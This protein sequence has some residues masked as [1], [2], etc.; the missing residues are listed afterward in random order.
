MSGVYAVA[1]QKGGV[2]K[3]TT[4]INL[5]AALASKSR[6]SLLIDLDPQG[7]ASSGSGLD[8]RALARTTADVLSGRAD[9]NDCILQTE[10]RYDLL[11]ANGELAALETGLLERFEREYILRKAVQTIAGRYRHIFIDCP[12]AQGP[13][14]LN[15][16]TAAQGVIV[17]IQC[18]YYAL[19]GLSALR[20]TVDRVRRT[21]NPGLRIEGILRT[22]YD[23]R[24]NLARDVSAE[25]LRHFPEV[26]Y[27]TIVPRNV[28]LAEAPSHGQSA[29]LYDPS[30]SGAGAYRTLAA[31]I[32][33]REAKAEQPASGD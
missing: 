31:E 25:L 32:R 29:I 12:P 20:D 9:I 10:D 14:T 13:L 30:S 33:R 8:A 17:P 15:G 6:R 23:S 4:A 27:K 16:L 28:T 2:G 22:M 11:P 7:N 26:V 1:N 3:T 19:E 24:N 18:E 21:T 5:A